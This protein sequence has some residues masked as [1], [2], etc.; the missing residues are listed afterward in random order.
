MGIFAHSSNRAFVRSGID[1]ERE[2]WARN[3][4]S[5]S[6]Q[7]CLMRSGLSAGQSTSSTPNSS[8][9]VFMDLAL[10]IEAQSC[11]NRKEPSP[12]CSHKVGSIA[13]S[14]MSCYAEALWFLFA[15]SEKPSS[16]QAGDVLLASAKP[17]LGHQT[18]KQRST[19]C[20]SGEQQPDSWKPS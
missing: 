4:C 2:G 10:C 18:A 13:L 11:W 9:H 14:K 17:R 15:G 1:V 3:L 7:R 20:H 8:N 6:S 19:I 16:S 12:N 5:R